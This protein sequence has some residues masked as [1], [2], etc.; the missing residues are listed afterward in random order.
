M[1]YLWLR[2]IGEFRCPINISHVRRSIAETKIFE[3]MM[4]MIQTRSVVVQLDGRQEI[5]QHRHLLQFV[6]DH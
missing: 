4:R 3:E 6:C 5:A 1:C 2:T